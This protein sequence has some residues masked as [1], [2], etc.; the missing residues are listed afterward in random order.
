VKMG[1][2]LEEEEKGKKIEKEK[3]KEINPIAEP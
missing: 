3:E 1:Q 2:N